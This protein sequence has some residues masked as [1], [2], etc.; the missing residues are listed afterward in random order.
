MPDDVDKPEEMPAHLIELGN[1]VRISVATDDL[2][3]LAAFLREHEIGF[4]SANL[5]VF[6]DLIITRRFDLR[7][8]APA[9]RARLRDLAL[10][11]E[12]ASDMSADYIGL[13]QLGIT[14][15]CRDCRWFVSAPNDGTPHG[16]KSCVA[17]GAKGIDVACIGFTSVH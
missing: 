8:L 2:Q 3:A 17:L 15:R 9:A 10:A 5:H 6:R 14:P 7:D 11:K 12:D 1:I 4:S 16:E 13:I